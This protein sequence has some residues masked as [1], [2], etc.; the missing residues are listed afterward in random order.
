MC[1][2]RVGIFGIE[3]LDVYCNVW[4]SIGSIYLL[5]VLFVCYSMKNTHIPCFNS[6]N[7]IEITPDL[8]VAN[9]I[10]LLLAGKHSRRKYRFNWKILYENQQAKITTPCEYTSNARSFE[11]CKNTGPIFYFIYG[12]MASIIK[13][14]CIFHHC[15]YELLDCPFTH[16]FNIITCVSTACMLVYAVTDVTDFI[17]KVLR[18][19]EIIYSH[20]I[21]VCTEYRCIYEIILPNRTETMVLPSNSHGQTGKKPS[22]EQQFPHRIQI[23]WWHSQR[24]RRCAQTQTHARSCKQT[25]TETSSNIQISLVYNGWIAFNAT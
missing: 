21:W 13:Q 15:Y 18:M 2:L 22:R 17:D 1:M 20:F 14:K 8:S 23:E 4:M 11:H 5:E 24:F 25:S 3:V 7:S 9:N 19:L 10:G 16:G 6:M 12:T